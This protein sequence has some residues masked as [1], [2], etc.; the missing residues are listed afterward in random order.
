MNFNIKKVY[1]FV[2]CMIVVIAI[3][4]GFSMMSNNANNPTIL[5]PSNL[6]DELDNLIED[7]DTATDV[8]NGSTD[9]T[10]NSQVPTFS[11]GYTALDFALNI[12]YNGKGYR[13]VSTV[14]TTAS[15]LG[16]IATQT[17][18]EEQIHSGKYFYKATNASCSNSI[19]ANFYRYFYSDDGGQNM[20]YRKTEEK[21]SDGSPNFSG[22]RGEE[23]ATLDQLKQKYDLT[24]GLPFAYAASKDNSTLSK[25][26]RV[27]NNKY[28]IVS[29]IID[30]TKIPQ[31]Y[32]QNT[33][34]AGGLSDYKI[35]SAKLTYYIEK[36]TGYLRQLIRDEQT[37]LYK[38]LEVHTSV[39]TAIVYT[40]M[41]NGN[42]TPQKPVF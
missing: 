9:K 13:A 37:T 33:I 32:I 3:A 27:T 20:V 15:T 4:S 38:G 7:N 24:L 19:G 40:H 23:T 16:I 11:N 1:I 41:N 17:V 34:N 22:A 26:D 14:N 5:P 35:H 25:F 2:V 36:Q 18:D 29:F 30:C 12:L 31:D 28:Y 10:Q 42:L 21:H 39:R 8:S 6:T